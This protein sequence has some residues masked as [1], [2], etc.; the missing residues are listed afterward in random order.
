M[1]F[2]ICTSSLEDV[3]FLSTTIADGVGSLRMTVLLSGVIVVV[4]VVAGV[5]VVPVWMVVNGV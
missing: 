3:Y 4:D 1:I 2:F 5:S